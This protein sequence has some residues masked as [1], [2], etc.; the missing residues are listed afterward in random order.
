MGSFE[1]EYKYDHIDWKTKYF[2]L[3]KMVTE[4]GVLNLANLKEANPKAFSIMNMFASVVTNTYNYDDEKK[5]VD[6]TNKIDE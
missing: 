6:L 1:C 2:I 3:I 4:P 5:I